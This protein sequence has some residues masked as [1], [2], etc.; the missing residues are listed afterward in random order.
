MSCEFDLR[1]EAWT[2]ERCVDPQVAASTVVAQILDREG[3][4]VQV[5]FIEGIQRG[6]WEIIAGCG[7]VEVGGE[8]SGVASPELAQCRAALEHETV[9]EESGL[10]EQAQ[11]VVLGDVQQCG[12]A[13][14]F[15]AL[16]VADQVAFGDAVHAL[17]RH[18]DRGEG[19]C[20]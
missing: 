18:S 8:P 17:R 2:A 16:V 15:G 19:G 12:I 5:H 6:K 4:V 14:A 9:I 11:R 10:V 1:T 7:E 3:E 20:R 13:S